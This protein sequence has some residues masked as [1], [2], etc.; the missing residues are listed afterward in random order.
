MRKI[1]V[2]VRHCRATNDKARP[3]WF[4]KE[5]CLRR[6]VDTRDSDT[7][8]TVVFDGDARGH[9]VEGVQGVAEIVEVEGAGSEACSFLATLAA[10]LKACDDGAV[11]DDD[12]VYLAED[13]Y[14]H[15]PGWCDAL[16]EGVEVFHYVS[17]YD[18]PDKYKS[19]EPPPGVPTRV[20]VTRSTHWRTAVSTT[21]TY[22]TLARVLKQDIDVHRMYSQLWPGQRITSDHEK[23]LD[24]W[25]RGRTL[26]TP[27]PA[28]ATHCETAHLAPVVDWAR[29]AGQVRDAPAARN[30]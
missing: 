13:D 12:I 29:E 2:F 5:A 17:P 3:P 25:A 27:M 22:A 19:A 11:A 21:N 1:H 8:V 15:A 4:D 23:F 7:R 9:F 14:W 6:L 16:R 10:V 24:L 18:H 26:G 28:R 20:E 30:E